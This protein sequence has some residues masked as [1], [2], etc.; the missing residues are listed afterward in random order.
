MASL[1][2]VTQQLTSLSISPAASVAHEAI[3][4]PVQW[5]Q[6]LEA[7]E[8]APKSFQLLKTIV[9]KPKTA[10]TA[11]P[12]PLV[13]VVGESVGVNTNSLGKKLNLKDLRIASDDLYTEFF[14][15]DKLSSTCL[16]S[17]SPFCLNKICSLPSRSR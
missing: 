10:K 9:Y 7:S 17:S 6:A 15:L 12:V 13:A 8:S 1:E 14:A 11:T 2:S 3:G 5:R 16:S 4:N